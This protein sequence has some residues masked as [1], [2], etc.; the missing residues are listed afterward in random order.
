LTERS[1]DIPLLV[2]HFL[3]QLVNQGHDVPSEFAPESLA[4]LSAY[5][6]PGNVRELRNVVEHSCATAKAGRVEPE[7]LPRQFSRHRPA[8]ATPTATHAVSS[9]HSAQARD[10]EDFLSLK[11]VERR[12][13]ES[14]LEIASGNKALAA[15][16][17]GLS[18]HQLYVKLERLRE[19]DSK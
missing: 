7:H 6:W 10:S 5:A 12:H 17:L 9:R 3:T 19:L 15:R 8:P 2:R 4:L 18:R 14:A 16:M 13:I 11:L 1:E